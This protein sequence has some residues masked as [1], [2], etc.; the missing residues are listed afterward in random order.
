MEKRSCWKLQ[1]VEEEDQR[2]PILDLPIFD[3][4]FQVETYASGTAIG[5]VLSKE[6]RPVHTSVRN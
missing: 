2:K 4:V 3:K 6:Q 5:V 1:I